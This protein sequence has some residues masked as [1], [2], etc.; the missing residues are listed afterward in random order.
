MARKRVNDYDA[1]YTAVQRYVE[2]RSGKIVVIGGIEIQ[3]WPDDPKC[4]FRVAVR[5]MG[6]KPK[7]DINFKVTT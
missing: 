2:N 1:L 6:K 5:C 7:T 4:S 3:E